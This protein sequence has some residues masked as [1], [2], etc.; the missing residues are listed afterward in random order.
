ML[1]LISVW[2]C[3]VRLHSASLTHIPIA[4]ISSERK[5]YNKPRS[6]TGLLKWKQRIDIQ[7]Q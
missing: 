2:L 7:S 5:R 3:A 4:S 6:V 1:T